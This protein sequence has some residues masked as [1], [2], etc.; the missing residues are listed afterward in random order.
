MLDCAL[1][2]DCMAIRKENYKT[3]EEHNVGFADYGN[4]IPK[5]SENIAFEG[6]VLMLVSFKHLWKYLAGFFNKE[7]GCRYANAL[8]QILLI[9]LLIHI[10]RVWTPHIV[11]NLWFN[12]NKPKQ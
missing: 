6:L 9:I 10:S 5:N 7:M 1:S 3:T 12:M 11:C 8:N 2:I 4:I